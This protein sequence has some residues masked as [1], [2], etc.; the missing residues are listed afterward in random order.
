MARVPH[1]AWPAVSL[2]ARQ[3]A[4]LLERHGVT[5]RKS[6]G[7]NFVVDPNTI[8]RIVRLAEVEAGDRIVEVGPGIGAL[9]AALADTGAD[10]TAVEIDGELLGPLHEHLGDRPVTV[11]HADAMQLDWT[12]TLG[13][14]P[15]VKL[16]AN[17]PYNVGTPLLLD[18][19]AEVP[20]ITEFTV[21]VQREVA[22]RLA[23]SPDTREYGIPSV[24]VAWWA[25]AEVVARVPPTVFIPRPNVDSAVV[26]IVRRPPPLDELDHTVMF[27]LVQRGFGQRRKMLRKSLSGVVSDEAFALAEVA[28]TARPGELSVHE[29]TAL[30][31]ASTTS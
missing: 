31:V 10:V 2:G 29:W 18:L 27:D 8:E 3:A 21:M 14:E 11:L 12:A 13:E 20:Q 17:L 5:P 23:A 9:T 24:K 30:A 1:K 15:G 4:E 19:L 22:E 26:R 16:V 7:Q 28:P 6:L 25:H